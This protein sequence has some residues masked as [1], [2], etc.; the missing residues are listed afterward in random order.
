MQTCLSPTTR[1]YAWAVSSPH[2]ARLKAHHLGKPLPLV[3]WTSPMVRMSAS[4]HPRPGHQL[5]LLFERDFVRHDAHAPLAHKGRFGNLLLQGRLIAHP[6]GPVGSLINQREGELADRVPCE[7]SLCQRCSRW[8]I[9]RHRQSTSRRGLRR[10][11]RCRKAA[12]RRNVSPPSVRNAASPT[13]TPA[14]LAQHLCP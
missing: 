11:P 14:T 7:Y 4:G 3:G 10:F 5:H 6:D 2:S 9:A 8:H 1:R 13:R 12:C